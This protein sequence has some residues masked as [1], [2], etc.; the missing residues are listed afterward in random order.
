MP[1]MDT[2]VTPTTDGT[3][4]TGIYRKPTRTELY[5]Q[6]DSHGHLSTKYSVIGTVTYRAKTVCSTPGLLGKERQHLQEVLMQCKK[7]KRQMAPATSKNTKP[8]NK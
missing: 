6:W 2:I 7:Q 1:S 5:L 4:S 3:L 8:A